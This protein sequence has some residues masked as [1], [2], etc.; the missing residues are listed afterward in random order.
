MTLLRGL[1]D[2]WVSRNDREEFLNQVK[3]VANDF[4]RLTGLRRR[5]EAVGW[6]EPQNMTV[7]MGLRMREW[8]EQNPLD[9]EIDLTSL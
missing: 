8:L 4:P 2:L 6:L 9:R 5:F 1:E 3:L 7:S